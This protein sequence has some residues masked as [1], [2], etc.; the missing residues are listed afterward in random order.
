MVR[1]YG[2]GAEAL[3]S[4]FEAI[5]ATRIGRVAQWAEAYGRVVAVQG[6]SGISGLGLS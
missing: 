1:K 2:R 6:L 5:D 3:T 4:P